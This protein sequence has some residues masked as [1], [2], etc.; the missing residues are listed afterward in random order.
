M[1]TESTPMV[2][3]TEIGV[4][5]NSSKTNARTPC[6][7]L[8]FLQVVLSILFLTSTTYNFT[9]YSQAEYVIFRDIMVML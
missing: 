8:G 2:P 5:L 6:I 3:F 1:V 4:P 9:E 7:L